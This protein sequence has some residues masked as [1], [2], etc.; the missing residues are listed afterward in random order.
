LVIRG[1]VAVGD[2][3]VAGLNAAT[4]D[5]R[6]AGQP[7]RLAELVAALS[8]G[9][10]LGFGQPMEHVLRQCMIAL[11]MAPGHVPA[12]ATGSEFIQFSTKD[13]LAETLTVM[14][15]NAQRAVQP[16]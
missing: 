8:L 10:D 5:S 15:A 11:R 7:V 4:T 13:Q 1:F 3:I 16:S 2:G 9:V 6:P 12:A 14:Q